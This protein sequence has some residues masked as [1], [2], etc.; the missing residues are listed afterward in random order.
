VPTQEIKIYV[1]PKCGSPVIMPWWPKSNAIACINAQC[2]TTIIV[3]QHQTGAQWAGNVAMI[4]IPIIVGLLV[5]LF[6]LITGDGKWAS[7]A[8][9]IGGFILGGIAALV[10]YVYGFGKFSC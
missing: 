1:C 4:A 3:P 2:G 6:W 9:V 7:G 5:L 8:G 10:A